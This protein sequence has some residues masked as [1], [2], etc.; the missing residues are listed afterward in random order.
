LFSSG[1]R[2]S[3]GTTGKQDR[4]HEALIASTASLWLS[5]ANGRKTLRLLHFNCNRT[6]RNGGRKNNLRDDDDP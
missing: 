2:K 1:S 5:G 6:Q 4:G 3:E